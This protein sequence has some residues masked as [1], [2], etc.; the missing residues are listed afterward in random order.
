MRVLPPQKILYP[1]LAPLVYALQLPQKYQGYMNGFAETA[2]LLPTI[3]V[4]TSL[5]NGEN[6]TRTS[7]YSFLI[8]FCLII[9]NTLREQAFDLQY[10]LSSAL[11]ALFYSLIAQIPY[12]RKY[13]S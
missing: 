3:D 10:I 6:K 8:P 12:Y 11:A 2:L 1:S 5:L 9:L 4:I 7:V 13:N